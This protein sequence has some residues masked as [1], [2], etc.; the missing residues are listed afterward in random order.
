MGFGVKK[1]GGTLGKRGARTDEGC[2]M[3]GRAGAGIGQSDIHM[4]LH[5]LVCNPRHSSISS[6]ACFTLFWS[7]AGDGLL[8]IRSIGVALELPNDNILAIFHN[9]FSFQSTSNRDPFSLQ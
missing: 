3:G 6:E 7:L 9:F 5:P 8:Q 1:T 2:A 4:K